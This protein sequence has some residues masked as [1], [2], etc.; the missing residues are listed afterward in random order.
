MEGERVVMG[1]WSGEG[2]VVEVGVFVG[3]ISVEIVKRPGDD[4]KPVMN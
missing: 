4:G 2:K 1:Y 3:P